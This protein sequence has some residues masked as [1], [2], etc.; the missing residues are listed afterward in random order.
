[1]G[2]LMRTRRI[3]V[4]GCH[5]ARRMRCEGCGQRRICLDYVRLGMLVVT[6]RV[7]RMQEASWVMLYLWCNG[8]S[9]PACM[10]R[11]RVWATS[12]RSGYILGRCRVAGERAC[13]TVMLSRTTWTLVPRDDMIAG[14][15]GQR[16]RKGSAIHLMFQMPII[17]AQP[18][19][20]SSRVEPSTEEWSCS[21]SD[22]NAALNS[23]FNCKT[24]GTFNVIQHST[25]RS[26][27]IQHICT[28]LPWL[29]F[30]F[31]RSGQRSFLHN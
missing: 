27:I 28:F 29:T 21:M 3:G 10:V 18:P 25:I 6:T 20:I 16:N 24:M 19:Q 17:D 31:Q 5:E 30:T 14:V 8:F 1:M 12:E 22:S 23:Q 13:H 2:R 11:M 26:N 15:E 7:P 9:M 4:E